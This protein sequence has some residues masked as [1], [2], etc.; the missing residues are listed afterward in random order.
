MDPITRLLETKIQIPQLPTQMV[1]RTHLF[2]S[3]DA[4]LEPFMRVTLVS[5]PA[6][7]GKTSL[8]SAWVQDRRTSTAWITLDEQDN[9][10]IR[11]TSYLMSALGHANPDLTTP[12]FPVRP[13]SVGDLQETTLVPLLNQL[14]QASQ[15]ILL[16]LD[17]YHWIQNTAV[18][19][20]VTY[21]LENLPTQAH[22]IFLTRADPA[23]PLAR[24]RAR[25]QLVELRMEDLQFTLEEAQSFLEWFG[26]PSLTTDQVD[27]LVQRTEGWIAGLQMAGISL[28]G[29]DDPSNF[30]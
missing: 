2:E 18:Q 27:M 29:C 11:F 13:F 14:G 3:L 1:P 4:A 8:V 17:D 6:G 26:A 19:Q 25:G 15:P 12:E 30:I 7:Y 28:Q 9:D 10:P 5:A 21:L 16:V 23:L 20:I 24:F 22:I